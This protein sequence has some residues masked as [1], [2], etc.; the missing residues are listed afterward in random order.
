MFCIPSP[1]GDFEP[2]T[3]SIY[4]DRGFLFISQ[5]KKQAHD[6]KADPIQINTYMKPLAQ[7]AVS[8]VGP[9][10]PESKIKSRKENKKEQDQHHLSFDAAKRP[11]NKV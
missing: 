2:F 5:C 7:P 11:V 1:L 9:E 8:E 10:I 6:A 3:L 4:M